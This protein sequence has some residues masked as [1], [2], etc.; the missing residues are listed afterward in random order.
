MNIVKT[1]M[2]LALVGG[3]WVLYLLILSS[4]LS[5]AVMIQKAIFFYKNRLHWD[6]F[7]EMLSGF[8]NRD[9]PEAALDYVR[10]HT[11]P[12]ARVVAAGLQNLDKGPDAVEEI[13]AVSD[14]FIIPSSNESFGLAALEAMACEVPVISS[15]AG[16]LPEV[17]I[18]GV[19]GFLSEVG[20]VKSLAENSLL[21]LQN[22][23]MLQTFRQN[24]LEQAK[25]F[26]ISFILPKYEDDYETILK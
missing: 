21:L 16:G 18:H 24:A 22:P 11:A 9:D 1:L 23:A 6:E 20:D 12:A 8:F 15:N 2:N 10:Q 25:R 4:V 26:D 17:N 5:L 3:D 7:A 14:L 13:L 19:T